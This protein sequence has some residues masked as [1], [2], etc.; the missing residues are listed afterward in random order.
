MADVK[1]ETIYNCF[2]VL[3]AEPL[4]EMVAEQDFLNNNLNDQQDSNI[5]SENDFIYLFKKFLIDNI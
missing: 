1:R 4:D 5:E 2:E 3:V